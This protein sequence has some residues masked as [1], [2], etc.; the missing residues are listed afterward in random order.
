[1]KARGTWGQEC[2][3]RKVFHPVWTSGD[4]IDIIAEKIVEV[5][6]DERVGVMNLGT[7]RKLLSDMAKAEY[8]EVEIVDS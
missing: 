6:A 1:M 3:L 7:E 4:W 2:I 5:I 8:P